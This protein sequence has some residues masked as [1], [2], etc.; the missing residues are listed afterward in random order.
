MLKDAVSCAVGTLRLARSAPC[1]LSSSQT[2][3]KASSER[4]EAWTWPLSFQRGQVQ[5][6]YHIPI[7]PATLNAPKTPQW[8]VAGTR[9]TALS[10]NP[11]WTESC[12]LR[13]LMDGRSLQVL[14]F[15]LSSAAEE[16]CLPTST[17]MRSLPL[18]SDCAL[19]TAK[20][21]S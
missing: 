4:R 19:V 6:S 7:A 9:G 16:P 12:R 21:G 13:G 17:C 18:L 1:R 5:S 20:P 11:A 14:A 2:C 10:C 8:V 15:L 3:N